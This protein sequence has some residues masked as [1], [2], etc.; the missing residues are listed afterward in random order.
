M[1]Q[2]L[3]AILFDLD[4]TLI[5]TAPDFIRIIKSLCKKHNLKTPSDTA[6]REQVS[7]GARAMVKLMFNNPNLPDDDTEL[8]NFRQLFLDEYE[9]NICIDSQL[10]DGL[11][12]LLLFLENNNIKWGIVTNKPKYLAQSLLEKL[13]LDKRCQ[14]L[15]C[16]DDVKNPKPDPESLLLACDILKVTPENCLY[17]GDHRRDIVAGNLAKM[18]TIIASYGYIPPNDKDLNDWG[19]D[20]VIDTPDELFQYIRDGKN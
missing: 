16:P 1:T 13:N 8:L 14:V 4:G 20:K 19:A 15:I 5:D 3:Q 9:Q 7:A 6:I 17:I 2:K 10:F 11:N 18:T 12:D